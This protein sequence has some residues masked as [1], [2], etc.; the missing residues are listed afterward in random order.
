MQKKLGL[1]AAIIMIGSWALPNNTAPWLS[2]VHDVSIALALLLLSLSVPRYWG[3]IGF[4]RVASAILCASLIPWLQW[5]AGQFPFSGD[6]WVSS[7]YLVGFALAISTGQAW[8]KSN[9]KIIS[10]LLSWAMLLGSSVSAAMAL[11]QAFEVGS[12]GFWIESGGG[13][14]RVGANLNQ[15]NNLATLIGFG[16][17]GLLYLKELGQLGRLASGCL[18][19][20]LVLGASVTQS[21]TALVYGPLMAAGLWLFSRRG[22]VFR[23]R[24][25]VMAVAVVFHWG[26][27]V[28]MALLQRDALSLAEKGL[29][30]SKRFLMWPVMWDAATSAPWWGYGWL[31]VGAA[32]MAAADRHPSG[33]ELWLHAHNLFLELILW[34]GFPLGLL[35]GGLLLYG[36]VSR[37]LRVNSVPAA[38]GM[39]VV[40]ILGAHSM[41]ELP[42]HYAYFLIPAGLWIGVVEA[43]I[44]SRTYGSAKAS[45]ALIGVAC[46]LTLA[47]WRDY[48][49]VEEDFRLMRFETLGIGNVRASKPAPDAPFL[50]SLTAFL[51][52]ARTVPRANMPEAE[53]AHMNQVIHRYPYVGLMVAYAKALSLNQRQDEA[54]RLFNTV[55]HIYG[56]E[57]YTQLKAAMQQ[58]VQD[59]RV[60][61]KG[62]ADALPP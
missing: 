12:F 17:V 20:L 28:A 35:L 14:M 11:T 36:F 61:L 13:Q 56:E 4:T 39:M 50:S 48:P 40:A 47:L 10:Q 32:Q 42:Y 53:L 23:T 2:F 7:T 58:E 8:A 15:P 26:M 22:V 60:D 55:R 59:G 37:I 34:C 54:L 18:F 41:M 24:F 19:L 31:Q 38:M 52:A 62:L 46:A 44:G 9:A 21:R 33:G 49:E 3:G 6:A 27:A 1:A 16:A 51:R 57:R 25:W 30:V 5:T 29:T 45:W 43:S